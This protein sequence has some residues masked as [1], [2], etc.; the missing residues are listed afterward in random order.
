MIA[1]WIKAQSSR[2]LTSDARL[3]LQRARY[4]RARAKAGGA[5]VIDYFHRVDDPYCQL[6]VQVIPDLI[7]RFGVKVIPHV[8]EQLPANMYPDPARYEALS[9]LDA[10]RLARLYGI[11]LPAEAVVPDR[12]SVQM[13]ARFLAAHPNTED[14]FTAAEEI[15]SLLWRRDVAAIKK[16]CA[17]AKMDDAPLRRAEALLASHHYYASASLMFEGEVYQGLDRLDHLERR[18]KHLTRTGGLVRYNKTRLWRE[19]LAA[20][21]IVPGGQVELFFSVRSPYSYLAL[22]EMA[23][24]QR[25]SGVDLVLRPVL[26]MMMRGLPVPPDKRHY[27]LA[28]TTREAR[29]RE[30]PWGFIQDPLG[31]AVCRAMSVGLTIDKPDAQLRF[32]HSFMQS[33][34]AEGRSGLNNKTMERARTAAGLDPK[35]G[36]TMP[37]ADWQAI[38]DENRRAMLLAG[39][40]AVPTF[41]VGGQTL[42]GQDR[43]WAVVDALQASQ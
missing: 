13:A 11:G 27:I 33:V 26:P 37:V 3:R 2:W 40:W 5:L 9:I 10:H 32:F 25:L 41:V 30:I 31:E 22:S 28:D 8:V 38:E 18:L 39:S 35:G 6:L 43:L 29:L 24:F 15:G 12:L 34:W 19:R 1:N 17:L 16:R 14:F 42:W 20:K 7:D 21:P 4:A 36:K 23:E